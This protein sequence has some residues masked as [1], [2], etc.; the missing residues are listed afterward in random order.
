MVPAAVRA[1]AATTAAAG[2]IGPCRPRSGRV[3]GG[4]GGGDGTGRP[5]PAGYGDRYDA[6]FAAAGGGGIRRGVGAAGGGPG[7]GSLWIFVKCR[8][9]ASPPPACRPRSAG[10][11]RSGAFRVRGVCASCRASW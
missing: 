10:W 1:D 7:G 8:P 5:R 4:G 9:P 6:A 11:R 2:N 3:S